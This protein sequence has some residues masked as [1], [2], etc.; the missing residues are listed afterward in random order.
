[1]QPFYKFRTQ[2]IVDSIVK[3]KSSVLVIRGSD[4]PSLLEQPLEKFDLS[5]LRSVVV[6]MFFP[7]FLLTLTHLVYLFCS[8]RINSRSGGTNQNEA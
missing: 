5:S 2:Y 8:W 4:L 3:D 1:V 6:G 7:S